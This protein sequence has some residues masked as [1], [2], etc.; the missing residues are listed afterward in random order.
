V[1]LTGD[2][3]ASSDM[4]KLVLDLFCIVENYAPMSST[5]LRQKNRLLEVFRSC[6]DELIVAEDDQ[7]KLK[8]EGS[9]PD[10]KIQSP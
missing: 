1:I 8:I 10:D 5:R 2:E 3:L 7:P 6:R 9:R 4:M